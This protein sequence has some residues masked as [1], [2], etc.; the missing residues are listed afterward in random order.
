L[1]RTDP[2]AIE[3]HSAAA[4]SVLA[5]I[6][7][8]AFKVVVGISTG[9]LGILAE[10]AHSGLDLAAA[11]M[12][13]FAVRISSRPADLRHPYGH[14]KAENISAL[15]ETLLLLATC[16]WILYSA[17]G[18][19]ET[20]ELEIEVT[21]WSFAVMATSI[22]VDASRS[23]VLYRAA[24]RYNSQALEADALHFR[25]DIWS[26]SVVIAGLILVKLS[27]AVP[28]WGFLRYGDSVAAMVVALIVVGV[29]LKLGGRALQALMDSAPP[30]IEEAIVNRVEALSGVADC[31]QVRVRYSGPL[32]FV[33]VHILVNGDRTL[34]EIHDLTGEV[35]T[36]IQQILPN[37]DI[38]VHPE[39]KPPEPDAPA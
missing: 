4:T 32:P 2:G 38:T 36:A 39:P 37:A 27:E 3:K 24:R 7:L 30:G 21:F 6:G 5:A 25:T 22:V 12:T 1:A 28:A 29:S 15:F 10:A 20:G 26:S 13:L 14:G 17:A 33:D 35:E 34:R 31:H 18:R 23:R 16:A 8:T 19:L 11:L 9:S